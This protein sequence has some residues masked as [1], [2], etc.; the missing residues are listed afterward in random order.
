[1]IF[2]VGTGFM[3]GYAL[4]VGKRA[5]SVLPF[6]AVESGAVEVSLGLH[7]S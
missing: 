5:E 3:P 7:V 4:N 2:S 1:V 6:S